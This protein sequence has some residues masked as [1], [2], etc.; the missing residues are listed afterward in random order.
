M[1]NRFARSAKE[2]HSAAVF[3]FSLSLRVWLVCL[4][5]SECLEE[6][7]WLR[8]SNAASTCRWSLWVICIP[9]D[10]GQWC[11]RAFVSLNADLHSFMGHNGDT[12]GGSH[13]ISFC[14][15][16]WTF[17]Y[18]LWQRQRCVCPKYYK[19]WN[20]MFWVH[21][22][23]WTPWLFISSLNGTWNLGEGNTHT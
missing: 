12:V 11:W 17:D 13:C 14:F 7:C 20:K 3:L 4:N 21:I 9:C 5:V 15:S 10:P 6:G 8:F 2:F 23:F 16:P 22:H 1:S 19:L 18:S